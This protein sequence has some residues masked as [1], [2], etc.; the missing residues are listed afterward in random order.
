[1][2]EVPRF[3]MGQC[4]TGQSRMRIRST[5]NLVEKPT[6]RFNRIGVLATSLT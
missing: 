3:I 4:R 1:M 5:M 2:T 6:E